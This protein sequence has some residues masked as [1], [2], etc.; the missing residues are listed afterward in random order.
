[1]IGLTTG[2]VSLAG[3]LLGARFP[4]GLGRRAEYMGGVVLLLIALRILVDHLRP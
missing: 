1:V 3:I 2:F 4:K